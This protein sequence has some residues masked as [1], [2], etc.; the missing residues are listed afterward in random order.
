MK[1][2]FWTAL[3]MMMML[4][5][6]SCQKENRGA[7]SSDKVSVRFVVATPADAQ[8]RAIADGKTVNFVYWAAFDEDNAPVNGL[9]GKEPLIDM[10]A[11][12]DVRLVKDY[13]YNFV[14][15]AHYED[16][17]GVQNA[18]DLTSFVSSSKVS[19][20]YEGLANDEYRDAFHKQEIIIINSP[21]ESRTIELVRPF[22]QI[23]FL[24]ADYQ[25]VEEV[26][27]HTSL[28]STVAIAGLPTVLNVLDGSVEGE[29]TTVLSA[30]AVPTDPAYYSVNGVQHGWYSMNYVLAAD[31]K[32]LN[33]VTATFT[34]DKSDK[35]VV[36][37]VPNVPYQRNH[38]TNIIGN[39]L[40]EMAEVTVVVLEEFEDPAYNIDEE[41]NPIQ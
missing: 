7:D 38:R 30:T 36:L 27:V 11:S 29:G 9:N 26:D 13:P 14:F 12:F 20:S 37:E 33:T 28:K 19:V 5:A 3:A 23:N 16:E 4:A 22:A 32:K 24:A 2:I 17:N 39:F 10:T 35:P 8:T 21:G 40:T 1:K 18:Y 31:E 41:G 6:V 25:S 15:W 34:H